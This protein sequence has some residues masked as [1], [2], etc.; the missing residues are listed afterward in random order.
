MF[1]ILAYEGVKAVEREEQRK[2]T[3]LP[4]QHEGQ[5]IIACTSQWT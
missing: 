5:S 4:L 1:T 2:A 3:V